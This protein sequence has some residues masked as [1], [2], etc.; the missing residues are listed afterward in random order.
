M[1][2]FLIR[3][4][5]GLF[6]GAFIVVILTG[7]VALSGQETLDSSLFLKNAAGFMTAGWFFTVSTLYFENPNWSLARQTFLHFLTV[8]VLYFVLAFGI[9]WI[10]F[11]WLSFLVMLGVFLVFYAI[12]WTAFYLYFKNQARKLNEELKGM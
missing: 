9:G 1:R 4:I 10:P 5:M 2:D 11:N 8:I 7:S 3:S 6:F 12:F